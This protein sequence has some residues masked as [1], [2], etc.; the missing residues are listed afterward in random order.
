MNEKEIKVTVD[1]ELANYIEGLQ[2][3]TESRKDLLAFMIG[4]GY[5]TNSEAFKAY[6][7]E[8]QEQFIQYNQAKSE[9]EQKYVYPVT[10]GVRVNWNLDF[11]TRELTITRV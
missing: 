4:N 11:G 10:N 2:Y 9:L 7:K 5:D 3:E 1:E 8:F 6:E